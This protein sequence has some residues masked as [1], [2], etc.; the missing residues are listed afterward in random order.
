MRTLQ[1]ISYRRRN[2]ICNACNGYS[3]NA[4]ISFM[5]YNVGWTGFAY[6]GVGIVMRLPPIVPNGQKF[7]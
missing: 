4:Y 5:H 6:E 3:N 2:E 7:I 1:A